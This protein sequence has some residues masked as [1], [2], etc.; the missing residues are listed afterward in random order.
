[1]HVSCKNDGSMRY[2]KNIISFC[3]KKGISYNNLVRAGQVHGKN[4]RVV[5]SKE[6]GL[7]IPN[8]DGLITKS[9]DTPLCVLIA[10]CVPLSFYSKNLCGILH[11][12]WRGLAKGI[13]EE[14]LNIINKN[15]D[16]KKM[17]FEIGPGIGSCHLEVKEDIFS[18]FKNIEVKTF[19]TIKNGNN[20]L[21]I[22]KAIK[23]ILLKNKVVKIKINNDCTFCSEKYFSYRRDK[24]NK[25]MMAVIKLNKS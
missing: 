22:K 13:V 12:G 21:D 25:R 8:T 19:V 23:H 24:T 4:I 17:H 20:F 3:N 14:A 10:D 7:V 16:I 9:P 15:E 5:T 2:D 6:R 11:I 1:M 18:Q